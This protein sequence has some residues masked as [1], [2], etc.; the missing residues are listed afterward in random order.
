MTLME[1]IDNRRGIID[2][3]SVSDAIARRP[4]GAALT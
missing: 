3:R 2:R 1:L 4:K